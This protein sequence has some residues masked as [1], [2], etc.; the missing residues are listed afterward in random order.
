[1]YKLEPK[2]KFS[3]SQF[4]IY[5][6]SVNPESDWKQSHI[7]QG[8]IRRE[9]VI[10][11]GTMIGFGEASVSLFVNEGELDLEKYER[12]FSIPIS[13]VSG[14]INIDGPEEHP[15]DRRVKIEPGLYMVTIGQK[16]IG[17]YE[18]TIDIYLK[19]ISS[20]S[21]DLPQKV[22]TPSSQLEVSLLHPKPKVRLL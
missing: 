1:M 2:L 8:F 4:F 3:F 5:D 14:E 6:P 11:V 9:G 17:E 13:I 19:N 22:F 7:N 16:V 12:V 18:E 21:S 15:T 20:A 10:V